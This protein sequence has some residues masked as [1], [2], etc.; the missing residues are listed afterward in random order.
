MVNPVS[1]ARDL[2]SSVPLSNLYHSKGMT[3]I[4]AA[5]LSGAAKEYFVLNLKSHST[6][7]RCLCRL[8]QLCNQILSLRGFVLRKSLRHFLTSLLQNVDDKSFILVHFP[9]HLVAKWNIRSRCLLH[10]NGSIQSPIPVI[11]I[12]PNMSD[13]SSSQQPV[14]VIPQS[15]ELWSKYSWLLGV[16]MTLDFSL[17]TLVDS[18]ISGH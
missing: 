5:L 6:T 15:T 13:S 10:L 17:R 14:L 8:R 16:M 9:T 18:A 12:Q 11:V 1:N 7:E 4:E 2:K 3:V